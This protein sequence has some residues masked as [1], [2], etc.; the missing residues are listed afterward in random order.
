[1]A[2]WLNPW[3]LSDSIPEK[4]SIGKF[5]ECKYVVLK[6]LPP[7][8]KTIRDGLVM[9][10][11]LLSYKDKDGETIE[12]TNIKEGPS[13]YEVTFPLG[14]H[15]VLATKYRG[16]KSWYQFVNP[17]TG[18]WTRI[19][20]EKFTVEYAMDHL[21]KTMPKWSDMTD[22]EKEMEIDTY[23]ENMYLFGLGRDFNLKANENVEPGMVTSFYRRYTPPTEGSKYGNI[24]ITKWADKKSESEKDY[25]ELDGTFERIPEPVVN[26]INNALLAPVEQTTKQFIDDTETDLPF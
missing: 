18:K 20:Q 26:A 8:G 2:E 7:K 4:K 12:V 11:A 1:M 19:S 16:P 22:T 23:F 3:E 6:V 25:E 13:G 5:T 9:T 15:L 24:I 14:K 21:S 10:A 17:E